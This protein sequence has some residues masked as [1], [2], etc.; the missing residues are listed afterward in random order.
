MLSGINVANASDDG[1]SDDGG[2]EV[3]EANSDEWKVVKD[4]ASKVL[5]RMASKA[6]V[7]ITL[8]SR[9]VLL[10]SKKDPSLSPVFMHFPADLVT[11]IKSSNGAG[12]T[13]CGAFI[14]ALLKGATEEDAVR[15]GMKTALLSLDCAQHAISPD[16]STLTYSEK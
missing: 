2:V 12:D 15:F 10:A 3:E 14:H 8:G 4:A 5:S 7:V 1:A 16:I 11:D 6:H 13:L 9:G